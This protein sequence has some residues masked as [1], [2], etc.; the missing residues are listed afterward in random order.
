MQTPMSWILNLGGAL[1]NEGAVHNV[2]RMLEARRRED[3]ALEA[4]VSH[5][6]EQ[7]MSQPV[8]DAA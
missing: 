4:L 7:P 5:L 8:A 1:S 3:E 2:E 6:P